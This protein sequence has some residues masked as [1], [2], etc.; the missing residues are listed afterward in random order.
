MSN[1]PKPSAII[2]AKNVAQVAKF[3]EGVLSMSVAH[4]DPDRIVL[5][6]EDFQLVIHA[7]PKQ[8]A[9]TIAI[10]VPPE[11]RE[12]T[13]I[14]LCLPVSSIAEARAKAAALGGKV[15][16]Q[17]QEWNGSDFRACDGYDPEGNVV[18]FRERLLTNLGMS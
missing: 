8:V 16:S 4:T 12:E 3:Y 17:D 10:A 5:N 18:Q 9:E 6:S 2:F 7:I 15:R 13:P 1:R 14:K 11:I